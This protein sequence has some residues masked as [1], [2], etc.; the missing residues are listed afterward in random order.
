MRGGSKE[1]K[2]LALC[3]YLLSF[4]LLERI[5]LPPM[6]FLQKDIYR[7]CVRLEAE[8]TIVVGVGVPNNKSVPIYIYVYVIY[9]YKVGGK[10]KF[11]GVRCAHGPYPKC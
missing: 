5:N 7:C 9:Q 3:C 11:I 8:P 6:W 10:K 2:T 4:Q 1:E